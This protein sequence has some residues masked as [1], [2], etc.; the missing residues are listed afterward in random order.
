MI[1][2]LTADFPSPKPNVNYKVTYLNYTGGTDV[3]T[4]L[5]FQYNGTAWVAE[6]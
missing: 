3:P 6:Q 4:V 2:V 1:L 5:T